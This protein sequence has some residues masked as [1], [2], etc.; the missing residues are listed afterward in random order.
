[1][2]KGWSNVLGTNKPEQTATQNSVSS[3]DVSTPSEGISTKCTKS[4]QLKISKNDQGYNFLDEYKEIDC[5]SGGLNIANVI[6]LDINGKVK[7]ANELIQ[8]AAPLVA[9]GETAVVAES[10]TVDG[11]D[12]KAVVTDDTDTTAAL[13]GTDDTSGVVPAVTVGTDDTATIEAAVK[14]SLPVSEDITRIYSANEDEAFAKKEQLSKE[15]DATRKQA[16]RDTN[17]A[18]DEQANLADAFEEQNQAINANNQARE[19][20]ILLNQLPGTGGKKSRRRGGM[21]KAKQNKSKRVK[22]II[23]RRRLQKKKGGTKRR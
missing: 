20:R 7:N 14:P 22:A 3:K 11:T 17:Q 8:R 15:T 13:V 5:N 21:K 1:M 10:E 2:F 23:T 18:L 16:I 9:A 12:E 19:N 6:E 4:V